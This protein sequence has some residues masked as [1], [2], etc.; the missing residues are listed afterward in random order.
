MPKIE[1]GETEKSIKLCV[2]H[3]DFVIGAPIAD[4]ITQSVQN[5]YHTMLIL[6]NDFLKS[7]WCM[8][9]FRTALQKS[10]QERSQHLIVVIKDDLIFDNI[11]QELKK[12]LST[13]TYL[14]TDD[15]FFWDKLIYAIK[16]KK[17]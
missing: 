9:E 10:L 3:R 2:H 7:Q 5:S 15:I 16:F 12:C 8:M 11:D 4:N 1:T 17:D 13:K 6:S 14:K